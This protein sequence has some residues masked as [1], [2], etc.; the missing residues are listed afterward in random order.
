MGPAPVSTCTRDWSLPLPLSL[1]TVLVY[2]QLQAATV[3]AGMTSQGRN[4]RFPDLQHEEHGFLTG[5]RTGLV[6]SRVLPFDASC[7][8][9]RKPRNEG[10]LPF[11]L[12]KLECD[13]GD[14]RG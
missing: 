7:Q 5:G 11:R 13:Q 4:A 1:G 14:S 2:T 6:V 10:L 3:F 8:G 12:A 9:A